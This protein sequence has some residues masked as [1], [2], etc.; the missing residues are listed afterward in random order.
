M[1]TTHLRRYPGLTLIAPRGLVPGVTP[2]PQGGETI[3]EI[4]EE[5]GRL[6]GVGMARCSVRDNYCK[7]I[8]RAIA[9]GRALK[10]AG[11]S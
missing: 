2:L 10:Y 6:V 4:E 7:H 5:G 9:T 3:V 1:R 8:G 11:L